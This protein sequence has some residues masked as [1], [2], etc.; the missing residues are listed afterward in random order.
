MEKK[1]NFFTFFVNNS[2]LTL[3]LVAAIVLVGVACLF[4]IKKESA[5]EVDFPIAFVN[6]VYPGAS[7]TDVEE[8][9]T[10]PLETQI[11]SLD[12]VSEISSISRNSISSIIV[13]FETGTDTSE[14]INE[15]KDEIDKA[16]ADLPSDAEDPAVEKISLDNFPIIRY[17]FTGPYDLAYLK[18]LTENIKDEVERIP[19]V[20]KAEI[21]GG[22]EREIQVIADKILLDHYGISISQITQA[23]ASANTDIPIGSIETSGENYNIRFDGRLK[24]VESIENIPITTIGSSLLFVKDVASVVDGTA[25]STSLAYLSMNGEESTPAISLNIYKTHEAD[26]VTISKEV[27]EA[28]SQLEENYLPENI[29]VQ[30][31][32]DQADI[33]SDD[34]GNLLRSGIFTVIIVFLTLLVFIGTKESF[35]AGLS[36]PLTFFITFIVIYYI[37]YSFNVISLFSLILALGIL[38]DSA[39]VVVEGMNREMKKGCSPKEAAI[40]TINE[41]KSSLISGTLTTIFVFVPM[42]MISGIIGEFSRPIPVTVTVVL[43]SSLFVALCL[44]TTI[45]LSVVKKKDVKEEKKENKL[46]DRL[47]DS[48]EG[49]IK[50]IFSDGGLRRRFVITIAVLFVLSAALPISGILKTD[51]FTEVDMKTFYIDIEEPYGTPLE[52]TR[53]SAKE[54]EAIVLEDPRVENMQVNIGSKV[55]MDLNSF[56]SGTGENNAYIIVNTFDK[57]ETSKIVS[58]LKKKISEID[59]GTAKVEILE[60]QAGPSTGAPIEIVV[61][62]EELDDLDMI[63]EDLSKILEEI[64]HT[65]NITTSNKNTNGEFVLSID[66]NKAEMYGLTTAQVASALR[67]AISGLDATVIRDNGEAIDVVV[68]YDLGKGNMEKINSLTI[69]TAQ[70]DIPL[71]MFTES[72]LEPTRDSIYHEDGERTVGI[73][74]YTDGQSSPSEIIEEFAEKIKGYNLP[75]GYEIS[76]EGDIELME[77]AFSDLLNALLIGVFAILML[78]VWQF[79]S[80][81]QP[82]FIVL[83]IPLTIIGIFPALTVLN[84]PLSLP[85]MIGIVALAGIV[86][87]NAIILIDKINRNRKSGMGK[88]EAIIESAKSR[89]RPIILTTL[90]TIIGLLPLCFADPTWSPIAYSI[91]FGLFFATLLTLVII[92]ILYRNFGE[93]E[94]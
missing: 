1:D 32:T 54:I 78:L 87:N 24:D 14:K 58:D 42:L 25:E 57:K 79:N 89:L 15:L 73:Y 77:Q 60:E 44:I 28:I 72:S 85:A 2:R 48:Y 90:T 76:Y 61:S 38:V 34:L 18:Q 35:L 47:A 33:I 65:A 13:Q 68:K 3:I 20:S 45:S 66:R 17:S 71:K 51:L 39:I 8:L 70:G 52:T 69:A 11:L 56:I 16:K 36:I 31:V 84:I 29:N 27:K 49:L 75:S 88:D 5:P 59:L 6:T 40:R 63:S 53:D 62:G 12:D 86:V 81:R 9:V 67:N 91:I 93:K 92:P 21:I 74:A 30:M 82:F 22:E 46:L 23:I 37:D 10:D 41:F 4:Q 94:L 64:P 43:L 55:S 83:I 26:T 80:F 50:K 7:A 19:G